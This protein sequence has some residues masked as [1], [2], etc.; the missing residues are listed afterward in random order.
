MKL[1][2]FETSKV[3]FKQMEDIKMHLER[4]KNPRLSI[5]VCNTRKEEIENFYLG[6]DTE[7]DTQKIG[8]NFI[9][10]ITK[11]YENQLNLTIKLI[12]SL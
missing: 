7:H 6:V 1:E 11:Y 9:N 4:L 3:A 8:A 2:N 12:E 10:S 5:L